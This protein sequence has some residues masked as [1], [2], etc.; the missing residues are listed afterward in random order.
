MVKRKGND[1]SNATETTPNDLKGHTIAQLA[2]LCRNDWAKVNFAA[3][4][5]L[6]AMGTLEHINDPYGMDSGKSIVIYFLGNATSW[7]GDVA[8]AVKKELKRRL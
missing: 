5:Y 2:R 4:P 7:R 6:E 8:R 3:V 1:M